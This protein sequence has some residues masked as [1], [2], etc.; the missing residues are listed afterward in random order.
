[1]NEFELRRQLREL[2]R[3]REPSRDLWAGI[4]ERIASESAPVSA[5]PGL[6][7][8]HWLAPALAASAVFAALL[9]GVTNSS[10]D[11]R[12]GTSNPRQPQYAESASLLS[13]NADGLAL[14]YRAALTSLPPVPV[15]SELQTTLNQ[16]D[17][18]A[19]QLQVALRQQPQSK[20]LLGQLRRVYARRLQ[21]SRPTW[22]S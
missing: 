14:E 9:I 10:K 1:M 22:L 5:S 20:F 18:S 17:S 13:R 2:R 15:P 4:A 12:D 11:G 7:R 19:E 3:E 16:L 6:S 21:L 8:H